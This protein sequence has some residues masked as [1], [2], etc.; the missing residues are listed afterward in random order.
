[1]RA[2]PECGT[3]RTPPAPPVDPQNGAVASMLNCSRPQSARTPRQCVRILAAAAVLAASTVQA[4]TAPEVSTVLALSGSRIADGVILG[5]DGSLYG[6]SATT[7]SNTGGLLFRVTPDGSSV[8]TLHQF[9][10]TDGI[11]PAGALLV[12]SDGLLYGT[13]QFANGG[14]TVGGG[15]VF[16]AATDGSGFTTLYR[17]A[18]STTE[19]V[20]GNPI[21]TDGVSP[22]G[23]LIEGSDG[24]LYGVARFGGPAGAGTVYKVGKDGSG[25]SL[26]HA[27]A[28]IT[29]A[30]TAA[31][32]VNADGAHPRAT[33][34]ESA[35]YFYGTTNTGGANGQGTI[36]RL[37]FDGSEFSLVHVFTT[38][39]APT[40][41][42]VAVNADGAFPQSGLTDGAD[43]L[44]Y[45]TA[46]IGGAN[47]GGVVYSITP[48]G[49]V[50]TTLHDFVAAD[51]TLPIGTLL[52]A[53]DGRL[54]GATNAGGL[55]SSGGASTL[56]TVYSIARDGTGF[57]KLQDFESAIGANGTGRLVQMNATDFF[58]TTTNGGRCGTGT[59]YRLSLTGATIEGD[60]S[61]GTS[62]NNGG[63]ALD[64]P[65]A[66][67]LIA[68]LPLV[69]L[70]RRRVAA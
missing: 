19:N 54:Y 59:I 50:R 14:V 9:G 49:A 8:T 44:L 16:R 22:H 35:G 7:T 61:C 67:L 24:F 4:Q 6:A 38:P 60:T 69:R 15:T 46:S 48:D 1:M 32:I 43:G 68:L 37:R 27:F 64:W 28:A 36:F 70:R 42:T 20:N 11:A 47:G 13:T 56:G 23:A 40:G 33:L 58:G 17:F 30:A 57:T 21:N 52:L 25:F 45:G 34:V 12:G 29:S 26:L 65:S 62:N 63:G 51:G 55:N 41:S 2:A 3:I 10:S 31:N 5:P 66:A 53:T 39:A 18:P